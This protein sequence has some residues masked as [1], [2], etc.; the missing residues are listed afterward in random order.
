[1]WN[2]SFN[3]EQKENETRKLEKRFFSNSVGEEP[4]FRI[5]VDYK[6]VDFQI[7]G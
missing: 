5:A 6:P 4:F 2:R 7:G 1:V 3:V